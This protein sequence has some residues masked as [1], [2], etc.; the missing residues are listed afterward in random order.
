MGQLWQ[1]RREIVSLTAT[2]EGKTSSKAAIALAK[3]GY[4]EKALT[5]CEEDIKNPKDKAYAL[6]AIA[7]AIGKL[8]QLPQAQQLL[9]KALSF[10]NTIKYPSPDILSVIAKAYNDFESSAKIIE[11]LQKN[12]SVSDG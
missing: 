12:T 6:T 4:L 1:M 10:S 2:V 9:E 5:I 11:I 3:D 8:N 7:E